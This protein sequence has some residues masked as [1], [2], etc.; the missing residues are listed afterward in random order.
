VHST[1]IVLNDLVLFACCSM[2]LGTGWS[3][4]LFSVPT[5]KTVDNY[6]D[7]IIPQL[8]LATRFLTVMT[9]VMYAVGAVMVVSEWHHRL[10]APV[11]VLAAVTGATLLTTQGIFPLNRQLATHIRDPAEL[12][13]VLRR[14][15]ALSYVRLAFWTVEWVTMA[16]YVGLSLG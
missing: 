10:W 4:A 9:C 1:L 13:S 3:L 8:A 14:W 5:P 15:K 6:Y 11:I 16:V 2:Y 7:Q 12:D